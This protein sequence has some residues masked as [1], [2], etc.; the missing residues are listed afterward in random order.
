MEQT[1]KQSA[2]R[3]CL[4][5]PSP[6]NKTLVL[7]ESRELDRPCIQ[8]KHQ[9]ILDRRLQMKIFPPK[10]LWYAEIP[11]ILIELKLTHFSVI[12]KWDLHCGHKCIY[13]V[14]PSCEQGSFWRAQKE[15][16]SGSHVDWLCLWPCFGEGPYHLDNSRAWDISLRP[17]LYL[18]PTAGAV[19]NSYNRSSLSSLPFCWLSL[20]PLCHGFH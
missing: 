12:A 11:W 5:H 9:I 20:H 13:G 3:N 2:Q 7:L 8:C 17:S 1:V 4:C 15:K 10:I 18:T 6:S 19:T 14:I 16:C